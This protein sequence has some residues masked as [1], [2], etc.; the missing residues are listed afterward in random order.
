[1][2]ATIIH[3]I[4]GKKKKK[5]REVNLFKVCN[6]CCGAKVQIQGGDPRAR[7]A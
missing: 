3:V 1:M 5:H 6:L 2:G 4:G 7:H